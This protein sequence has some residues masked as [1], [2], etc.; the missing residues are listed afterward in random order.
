MSRQRSQDITTELVVGAFVFLVLLVL[1]AFT[2]VISKTKLFSDSYPMEITFADI[3]G[4]K[5]G[6]NVFMRGMKVGTVGDIKMLENSPEVVATLD[7][8]REVIL[9]ED[10]NFEVQAASMLGGMRLVIFEGSVDVAVRTDLSNLRGDRPVSIMDEAT[11]SLEYIRSA[12][13]EGGIVSNLTASMESLQELSDKLNS[14]TGTVA[15]LI[16]EDDLYVEVEN[17]V[18]SLN[19]MADDLRGITSSISEGEGLIGKLLSEEDM[20][21]DDVSEIIA[22]LKTV[23]ERLEQGQ[24]TIGKL[25]SEDSELYNN[26]VDASE[27]FKTVGADLESLGGKLNASDGTVGKLINDPELYDEVRELVDNA[28]E[29]MTE[30]QATI[31]DL[32]ETSPITTF[33]SILFGAF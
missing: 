9:R 25:L 20:L 19:I 17:F 3:G 6:E 5:V 11:K 13:E 18:E 24:G 26:L 30:A 23:S 21:Y 7:L 14:G 33:S 29:V 15:R 12:L 8:D 1:G 32:R 22:N 28:N 27:S 4:L 16:N 31:D 2:I 10:C